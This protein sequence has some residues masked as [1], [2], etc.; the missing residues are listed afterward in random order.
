MS[1]YLKTAAMSLLS[2]TL[3]TFLSKY[4]SDVDVEGVAL[5]SVYDGSGWGVR[6]SNVKLREGVELMKTMPGTMLKKRTKK[7]RGFRK[8]RRRRDRSKKKSN[9]VDDAYNDVNMPRYNEAYR[10]GNGGAVGG[11]LKVDDSER[12][13]RGRSYSSSMTPPDVPIVDEAYMSSTESLLSSG[14]E[15]DNDEFLSRPVTPV[16]ERQSFL[17]CFT[18]RRTSA[19]GTHTAPTAASSK[20]KSDRNQEIEKTTQDEHQKYFE[21][22]SRKD[23]SSMQRLKGRALPSVA[24][25]V[26]FRYDRDD[27]YDGDE[28]FDDEDDEYCKREEEEEYE[29]PVRL[30]LG[31]DGRVGILDVRLIGKELHVM[32]E[33]ADVTIEAIPILEDDDDDRNDSDTQDDNVITDY[34]DLDKS[35]RSKAEP[36][37]GKQ[38]GASTATTEKPKSKPKPEPKRETVGDRVLAD[39]PLAR[40]ISSIPHLF[41]RDVRIRIIVR[42]QAIAASQTQGVAESDGSRK[43]SSQPQTVDDCGPKLTKAKPSY[44]D[45][46]VEIGIDFLS[47]TSGDDVL[48]HFHHQTE[49]DVEDLGI[50][51]GLVTSKIGKPPPL[52][53]VPSQVIPDGPDHTNEYL[54]R[55]IRTSRGPEGG[56]FVQLYAPTPKQHG[57]LFPSL[58]SDG[59]LWAR[60]QWL[61]STE[62]RLLRL[63]G[64]DLLARIHV[65]TKKVDSGYSWFYGEYV[66]DEDMGSDI[67]DSLL[68]FGGID[69]VAPGPQLPLP[70]IEPRM[71][72]GL[73]PRKS[74]APGNDMELPATVTPATGMQ[75]TEVDTCERSSSLN[76]GAVCYEVDKNGIQ[77]CNIPSLFHRISRGMEPASCKNCKHLPS[78]VCHQCWQSPPDRDD[79]IQDSSLDL[80]TPMPGLVLQIGLRDP[81][82]LNIDRSSLETI[83]ILRSLFTKPPKAP[84]PQDSS[85]ISDDDG[86]NAASMAVAAPSRKV[87]ESSRGASATTG[88]FS[89]LFYGKSTEAVDEEEQSDAFETYMQPETISIVGIFASKINFRV[90][91]LKPNAEDR[92]LA[93]CYWDVAIDCLTLDR[94]TLAASEKSFQDV[95]LDVGH[96]IWKEYRGISVK[97]LVSLGLPPSSREWK[98][99]QSS[100]SSVMGDHENSKVTWPVR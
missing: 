66:E 10:G 75:K 12:S 81:V 9:H 59:D 98:R 42:D 8:Q 39:N 4:L 68:V 38:K 57:K 86:S 48:S 2:R 100:V 88:F 76:A 50:D 18:S 11:E 27:E 13:N 54:V 29:Q 99:L 40:L 64:L 23:E 20:E 24:R 85:S 93:F 82:E 97:Q 6:L 72:R 52:L 62:H 51:E 58:N 55:Q 94:Q 49:G 14:G 60:Q 91:V 7:C 45:T 17:S 34:D 33:D 32:I 19:S 95:K 90:H 16:Q 56:F 3:Q 43:G 96:L 37:A 63:S 41:L 80:C 89:G 69:T 92:G 47:V 74:N 15:D 53:K 25:P 31:A 28:E 79:V 30:C 1:T 87:E 83:S 65:G 46:M 5:P 36:S 21:G 44:K 77:Y 78:E 84:T 67:D 26:S 22:V 73:T 35:R 61:L 71:S 70:P